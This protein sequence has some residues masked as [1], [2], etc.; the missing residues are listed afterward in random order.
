M[1]LQPN[2]VPGSKVAVVPWHVIDVSM[3]TVMP[4]SMRTTTLQP[5]RLFIR[6]MCNGTE[7]VQVMRGWRHGARP[8]C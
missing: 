7:R 2:D 1:E 5:I 8:V 3:M 6:L 4:S